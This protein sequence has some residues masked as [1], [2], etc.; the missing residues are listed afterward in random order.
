MIRN[1]DINLSHVTFE[2]MEELLSDL[3][4]IVT[5]NSDDKTKKRFRQRLFINQENAIS[6]LIPST[7]DVVFVD[8]GFWLIHYVREERITRAQLLNHFVKWIK[9]LWKKRPR[10]R[11]IIVTMERPR[12]IPNWRHLQSRKLYESF[13][14]ETMNNPFPYMWDDK[15][16]GGNN[17]FQ[18]WICSPESR[19]ECMNMLIYDLVRTAPSHYE[20]LS[21]SENRPLILDCDLPYATYEISR[22]TKDAK[23]WHDP[24][25]PGC[26]GETFLSLKKFF[27][28]IQNKT[29]SKVTYGLRTFELFSYNPEWI[30]T[31]I[32]LCY[33]THSP[34]FPSV[35]GRNNPEK[36]WEKMTRIFLNA[37]ESGWFSIDSW[38][39]LFRAIHQTL[40]YDP[41]SHLLSIYLLREN[42]LIQGTSLS[43]RPLADLWQDF[44]KWV[45]LRKAGLNDK[46]AL[47]K[48]NFV[49]I[50]PFTKIVNI[51]PNQFLNWLYF[52]TEE[53]ELKTKIAIDSKVSISSLAAN[54][55]LRDIKDLKKAIIQDIRD[56]AWKI[57]LIASCREPDPLKEMI[58]VFEDRYSTAD[59]IL[60]DYTRQHELDK[61]KR[62]EKNPWLIP[63]GKA[64]DQIIEEVGKSSNKKQFE[65]TFVKEV[66][67]EIEIIVD[68]LE[69]TRNWEE[70]LKKDVNLKGLKTYLSK[71]YSRYFTHSNVDYSI[72]FVNAIRN[73]FWNLIYRT[74]GDRPFFVD[75]DWYGPFVNWGWKNELPAETI[76]PGDPL[77]Y[78][79]SKDSIRSESPTEDLPLYRWKDRFEK[80]LL[81]HEI[82]T[83][84]HF[85][86]GKENNFS[87]AITD[88]I[89]EADKDGYLI[90]VNNS[91]PDLAK[92][93]DSLPF[94]KEKIPAFLWNAYAHR[95]AVFN[96]PANASFPE[97]LIFRTLNVLLL[98]DKTLNY[99]GSTNRTLLAERTFDYASKIVGKWEP[100]PLFS[101]TWIRE[102][103]DRCMYMAYVTKGNESRVLEEICNT[104]R[105][106]NL[107]K[108]GK[109]GLLLNYVTQLWCLRESK[110]VGKF[111]IRK[112]EGAD[113]YVFVRTNSESQKMLGK[114]TP[115]PSI[116]GGKINIFGD[117]HIV[118]VSKS[119]NPYLD[120]SK[121]FASGI[122][123]MSIPYTGIFE[124]R[125]LLSTLT[126]ESKKIDWISLP[127]ES[128]DKNTFPLEPFRSLY[129]G[130]LVENINNVTL[131]KITLDDV[132]TQTDLVSHAIT[133]FERTY[134]D[135]F[136]YAYITPAFDPKKK[137]KVFVK[138]ADTKLHA[139]PGVIY[140]GPDEK[141]L[142][143]I[144]FSAIVWSS[145]KKTKEALTAL[146]YSLQNIN[147][148][149]IENVTELVV[150]V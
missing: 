3:F 140:V 96:M 51:E 41:W 110:N 71:N 101:D 55:A 32:H 16:L 39:V 116:S 93:V 97:Y 14:D 65:K 49:L 69:K 95:I 17:P 104:S 105:A 103:F 1:H 62:K 26:T 4:E 117:S 118:A 57:I 61:N 119:G 79:A 30:M 21:P 53:T 128:T 149:R 2:I 136:Y 124:Q 83:R 10:C 99:L 77:T 109:Y 137:N 35:F 29:R 94:P 36:R 121:F 108:D 64:I 92:K 15:N 120:F 134:K 147:S 112:H 130:S 145:E 102:L 100:S 75:Q 107:R 148:R 125:M 52:C 90:W 56:N 98:F 25:V 135:P 81:P 8:L 138:M 38:Y 24:N 5:S 50:D 142:V 88:T 85:N 132:T 146:G 126:G 72:R 74:I 122:W 86:S 37:Q 70:F 9:K 47:Q 54:W 133:S 123:R 42:P 78:Y 141:T 46:E 23:P 11:M 66:D 131:S 68:K 19:L 58:N 139:I 67:K 127:F 143:A 60:R 111:L 28:L 45:P 31:S 48:S 20:K 27:E 144:L 129:F 18:S 12:Y 113:H 43:N 13:C 76:N 89:L 7:V 73:A 150:D 6:K 44:K 115:T 82:I 87:P 63:S 22:K 91:N 84:H 34:Y 33:S 80:G 106:Q 59:L 114:I 40:V